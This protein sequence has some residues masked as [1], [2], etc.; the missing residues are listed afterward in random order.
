[1]AKTQSLTIYDYHKTFLVND[2]PVN[3]QLQHHMLSTFLY[4]VRTYLFHGVEV[5][6]NFTALLGFIC[7][8]AVFYFQVTLEMTDKHHHRQHCAKTRPLNHVNLPER[9]PMHHDFG[10]ILGVGITKPFFFFCFGIVPDL[11]CSR[12]I[13]YLLNMTYLTA[14]AGV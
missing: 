7:M 12:D 3:T 2:S 1:M 11:F 13:G 5:F 14:V 8:F 6:W 4:K 9:G 10:P